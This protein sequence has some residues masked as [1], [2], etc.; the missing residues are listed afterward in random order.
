M[1]VLV[2]VDGSPGAFDAVSFVGKLLSPDNDQVGLYYAAPEVRVRGR[3]SSDENVLIRAR[4]ALAQAV[5]DESTARLPAPLR[6][7]VHTIVGTQHPAHGLIVAGEK[8]W[9]AD[10]LAVGARG[11][12]PIKQLALGSVSKSVVHSAS[13]PVLVARPRKKGADSGLRVLLSTDCSEAGNHTGEVLSWFTWPP[14]TKGYV[15]SVL[16]S[17]FAG[18]VPPWLEQQARDADTDAMAQAWVEEHEIDRQ[19][20]L[21]ALRA[22]IPRLSEI[23]RGQEPMVPE[24]Y[25]SEQVLEAVNRESIDLVAVGARGLKLWERLL[26]GSTSEKVLSYAPCS[27]LVVR[28]L[29]KP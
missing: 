12:G 10:M 6:D 7:R 5:F 28:H 26:M 15:I 11:I 1:K 22:L 19:T 3:Q 24:G 20:K 29:E 25:P 14:E 4:G 21:E 13:L 27:V 18:K 23:F 16:E 9:R 17:M 8:D 2:G